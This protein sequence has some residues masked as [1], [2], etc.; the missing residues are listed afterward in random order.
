M[1]PIAEA[2]LTCLCLP[3]KHPAYDSSPR[4]ASPASAAQETRCFPSQRRG[5]PNLPL[6]DQGSTQHT[7]SRAPLSRMT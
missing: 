5:R 7:Y 6:S 3:G 1:L 2:G 4:Q